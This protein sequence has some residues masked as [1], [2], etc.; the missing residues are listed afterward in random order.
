[1]AWQAGETTYR[2][3]PPLA[4]LRPQVSEIAPGTDRTTDDEILGWVKRAAETTYITVGTC[5]MGS[6]PMAVHARLSRRRRLTPSEPTRRRPPPR[7]GRRENE[8]EPLRL[9]S[10]EPT[11][12]IGSCVAANFTSERSRTAWGG[13]E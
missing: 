13:N 2:A 12:T 1:C 3:A 11:F 10:L 6:D 5:K 9:L 4:I 7:I 8:G